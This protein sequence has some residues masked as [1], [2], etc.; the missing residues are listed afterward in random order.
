MVSRSGLLCKRKERNKSN[1]R[2]RRVVV[3]ADD[4]EA[5]IKE[6]T[7]DR[8]AYG[9]VTYPIVVW[10]VKYLWTLTFRPM[11]K[12]V[13]KKCIGAVGKMVP[14]S[15]CRGT[16]RTVWDFLYGLRQGTAVFFLNF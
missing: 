4:S 16:A 10:M 13:R 5:V 15:G 7:I 1:L 14:E 6:T 11:F 8:G 9:V 3:T 2:K 12:F